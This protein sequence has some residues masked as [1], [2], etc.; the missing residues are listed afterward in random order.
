[1]RIRAACRVLLALA[2]AWPIAALAYRPFDSTDA[3]V[4]DRGELEMELGPHLC[5]LVGRG[6]ELGEHDL[7]RVAGNQ[8]Q[9]AEDGQ[10]DPE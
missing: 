1:M 8:E 9:H 2:V 10:R 7:D 5:D 3:A 6:D 4:A